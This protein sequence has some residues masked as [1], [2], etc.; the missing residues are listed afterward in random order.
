[1]TEI[2]IKTR[3]ISCDMQKLHKIPLSVSISKVLQEF[4]HARWFTCCPWLLSCRGYLRENR[5]AEKSKIFAH[6]PLT[7]EICR[8]PALLHK[9]PLKSVWSRLYVRF[10]SLLSSCPWPW[11]FL[12]WKLPFLS[13][14]GNPHIDLL[15]Y[16]VDKNTFTNTSLI[17]TKNSLRWW[18]RD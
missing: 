18:S 1:M 11:G 16:G 8:P 13:S 14:L 15:L 4:G 2:K 6:W 7:E 10:V 5:W 9:F 17:L 3:I 12:H